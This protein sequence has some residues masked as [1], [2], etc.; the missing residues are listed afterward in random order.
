MCGITPDAAR[1]NDYHH[2]LGALEQL[3]QVNLQNAQA[4]YRVR[5][6]SARD[7]RVIVVGPCGE[8]RVL[9]VQQARDL[10]E[11]LSSSLKALD[12]KDI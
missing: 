11:G 8:T 12:A 9:T 3:S 5:Y 10:F 4:K 2:D 1:P 6:E 7:A